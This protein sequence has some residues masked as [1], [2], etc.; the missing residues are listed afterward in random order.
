MCWQTEAFFPISSFLTSHNTLL[1][2]YLAFCWSFLAL[3]GSTKLSHQLFSHTLCLVRGI[4]D[5]IPVSPTSPVFFTSAYVPSFVTV[6]V[7]LHRLGSVSPTGGRTAFQTPQTRPYYQ[8]MRFVASAAVNYTDL[9]NHG[10][11]RKVR[12]YII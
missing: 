4:D 10:C 1:Q 2:Q 11:V 9:F 7:A 8:F 12:I 5:A 6:N 3:F